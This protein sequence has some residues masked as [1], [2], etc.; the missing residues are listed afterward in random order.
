[1][2]GTTTVSTVVGVGRVAVMVYG[3]VASY[4]LVIVVGIV[5]VEF[6]EMVV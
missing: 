4:V 1:V 5:I 2:N 3:T 6:A